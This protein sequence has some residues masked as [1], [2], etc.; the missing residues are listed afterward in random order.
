V[1]R[2][3]L[4]GVL[5][6]DNVQAFLRVIREGESNQNE[7]AFQIMFGGDHFDSFRDHPRQKHTRGTLTST[8]AG[9]YQFLSRTWDEMAAKYSLP[10]F[11]PI[12]QDIAAVGLIARRGALQ[13]VLDGRFDEAIRKCNREWASLPGSP[14]GQ[15]TRT[16]AQAREVFAAYG[17]R[18]STPTPGAVVAPPAPTREV[19]MAPLVLP[20][21]QIASSLIPQLGQL[22][23]SGSEVA[24]RNVAAGT[25]IADAVVKATQSVNLQE[26]VERIQTDPQALQVAKEAVNDVMYSLSEAGGGGIEGARKAATSAEGQPFWLQGAF[27]ISLVLTLMPFML[28]VDA[29]YVHPDSYDGNLR[30]QIVTGVMLIISIVGAFWLGSTFGSQKKDA[31]LAAR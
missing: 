12:N 2:D 29:F 8:A 19:K 17:G 7:D 6:H 21:L 31:A 27:Y 5:A 26:A 25:L 1:T 30:T 9:A 13:D 28:L 18:I 4:L 16:L 15:P 3:D 22:F 10:D 14:Y 23:G 20:L 11:S 24:Q